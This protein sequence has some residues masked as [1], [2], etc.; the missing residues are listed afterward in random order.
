V[1]AITSSGRE[2]DVNADEWAEIH[3]LRESGVPIKGIAT[4]L[5]M[6]RNTVRRALSFTSPPRDHRPRTGSVA[7]QFAERI[8]ALLAEQPDLTVAQIGEQI[9][10]TRS[11]T[12]LSRRVEAIRTAPPTTPAPTPPHTCGPALPSFTTEFI[13]RRPEL[14]ALRTRLGR[15]RLVT[16]A[17]AG[18][19]GKTRLAAQAAHE[20]RRAFDDGARMVEL[21]ALRDPALVPQAIADSLGL[22]HQIRSGST[23]TASIAAHL[24]DQHL[25]LVLDNCE[26]VRDAVADFVAELLRSSSRL[27]VLVTTRE[28][29]DLPGEDVQFLGP[30]PVCDDDDDTTAVALF[31]SRAREVLSDFTVDR[32]NIDQ[33]RRVCSRLD[34]IPLAIELACI[35]LRVLSLSE[36]ADRLDAGL[37]LLSSRSRRGE[38][39][40]S[41][42]QAAISWSYEL[43]TAAQ[44]RLWARCS[45]FA[46]GFDAELA[47]LVCA[48]DP[49]DATDGD[50]PEE[51]VLDCLYDLVGKSVLHRV[52]VAGRVRFRVLEPIRE[53][54][55]AMLSEAERARLTRR[56]LEGCARRLATEVDTW[57]SA[58]QRRLTQQ[59]HADL[60]NVRTA[61]QFALGG[62]ADAVAL[63][64]EV[65]AG[66]WFLWACGFSAAEHVV[67]L[68]RLLGSPLLSPRQRARA[69]GTVG[70]VQTLV[71]DRDSARPHLAESLALC[72]DLGDRGTARAFALN[73]LGLAAFYD[74]ELRRGEELLTQSL[75]LYEALVPAARADLPCTVLVHQGLLAC[76]DGRPAQAGR[77]F[78]SVRD[79]CE[80]ADE[81][82]MRSY[83]T[84]GLGLVAFTEGRHDDAMALA[85]E[86]L[87]LQESFADAVGTPLALELLGWAEAVAGSPSRSA[88]LLGASSSRWG[89]FGRQLYGSE[90]WI[91][92]RAQVVLRARR[93]LGPSRFATCQARG[94]GMDLRELLAFAGDRDVAVPERSEESSPLLVGLS[95]REREVATHLAQG[96]S[97]REIAELLVLSH[98]TIEGH[99]ERV[100]QKLGLQNRNQVAAAFAGQ[101]TVGAR[102]RAAVPGR[103]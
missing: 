11:R 19:V 10:W 69:L 98:R 49:H 78:E 41:S 36:L 8:S 22:A 64:V 24:A 63:A 90:Q 37:A 30:L 84:Y 73:G 62:D 23:A 96:L 65:L 77:L 46:G 68:E 86:S 38:E 101:A 14:A 76:F 60:P 39:R 53:F 44:R 17:G 20:F 58:D 28:L 93:E 82:W 3:R 50:L 6:S 1:T 25:L 2:A 91:A 97:N 52:E 70:M 92:Q 100:L 80:A 99:V 31:E 59:M 18:G 83:A 71:G 55:D 48:D 47:A 26:Q 75:D 56:L 15:H 29:L 9:G 67:W 51:A 81:S 16:I 79:R 85:R 5:A 61:L 74:G 45:V 54:G 35:R 72:E 33:V 102:P 21:S 103:A 4:T 34:G 40:H 89:A 87:R 88:I 12:T 27:R 13:G 66:P 42:M 95:R 7:D 57:F 94:A 43:C 32:D